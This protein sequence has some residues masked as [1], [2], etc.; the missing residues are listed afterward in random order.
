MKKVVPRVLICI[1]SFV[2][3][4][5]VGGNSFADNAAEVVIQ[6]SYPSGR[7][8]VSFYNGAV[9][10]IDT[11][12]K[13]YSINVHITLLDEDGN[14]ATAGPA[15]ESLSGLTATLTT[16]LGV[17]SSIIENQFLSDSADLTFDVTDVGPAARAHVRYACQTGCEPGDD[18][19]EVTVDSLTD[20]IE[21][22]VRAPVSTSLVARTLRV[23]GAG[24]VDLFDTISGQSHNAGLGALAGDDIYFEIWAVEENGDFTFAPELQGQVVTVNAYADYDASGTVGD[25]FLSVISGPISE[26]PA[27]ATATA[28]MS[29]GKATGYI[30]I[31]EAGNKDNDGSIQLKVVLTA[32]MNSVG[33]SQIGTDPA[34]TDPTLDWVG[35][36]P[37][38]KDKFLIGWDASLGIGNLIDETDIWYVIDDNSTGPTTTLMH[39]FIVDEYGNPVTGESASIRSTVSG[40]LADQGYTLVDANGENGGTGDAWDITAGVPGNGNPGLATIQSDLGNNQQEETDGGP[41]QSIFTLEDEDLLLDS[42]SAT[43]WLVRADTS[44]PNGL[45][46]HLDTDRPGDVITAG[47]TVTLYITSASGSSGNPTNSEIVEYNDDLS[48]MVGECC[49]PPLMISKS[50][51]DYDQ[52]T[53]DPLGLQLKAPSPDPTTKHIEIPIRIYGPCD[54]GVGGVCISLFDSDKGVSSRLYHLSREIGDLQP[55]AASRVWIDSLPAGVA[56]QNNDLTPD[57]IVITSEFL[58]GEN[59][60]LSPASVDTADQYNNIVDDT[61]T[62][63]IS[64]DTGTASV[65]GTRA[66]SITFDEDD[67]GETATVTV[68]VSGVGERQ[69]LITDILDST[70]GGALVCE[71]EGP[72]LPTPGGETIIQV[73][74]NREFTPTPK[75]V[76]VSIDTAS[77]V[78]DS[79]LRDFNG[80]ALI[81]P[82][83]QTLDSGSTVRLVVSAPEEGDVTVEVSDLSA[84]PFDSGT[85]TVMFY[86]D[87]HAP[88]ASIY[89]PDGSLVNPSECIV[90]TVIDDIAVDLGGTEY[91]IEKDGTDITNTLECEKEGH[92]TREG[93]ITC[94][95][96]GGLDPGSYLVSVTPKDLVGYVGTEITSAFTVLTCTLTVII[97]P[98]SA[99]LNPGETIQF[100]AKTT[101]NG[102]TLT[103]CY[104]WEI[105]EGCGTFDDNGL[106]TAGNSACTATITVTD[107]CNGN[108]TASAT[109]AVSG[110]HRILPDPMRRSRWVMLPTLM[111][112]Q[113]DSANFNILTSR[114]SFS[115]ARAVTPLPRLVLG[116]HTIWQ[117]VFVNPPWLAG[118]AT[119]GTLTVTVTTGTET[120]TGDTNIQMLPFGLDVQ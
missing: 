64:S 23:P 36:K 93:T 53:S 78:M 111:V 72:G 1:L 90:I 79:E 80:T 115:P 2:F 119:D 85:C 59:T 103:G 24:P 33:T 52:A 71:V 96:D 14:P 7:G 28:E 20:S 49:G 69:L 5:G 10:D 31:E 66:A 70:G 47:D 75:T 50:T 18:T 48:I 67:I 26:D 45:D 55:A 117:L 76:Q 44:A 99:T 25:F 51:E 22:D 105:S 9:G 108:I 34:T 3:V 60:L 61:P 95:K 101:C 120:V 89:P 30:T 21:V 106:F 74:A 109:V 13:D 12:K 37:G 97:T 82:T 19:L 43:V 8:Y 35:M 73:K 116:P 110:G 92:G 11:T 91:S 98:A 57:T 86:Y 54:T 100:S 27:I 46:L 38:I 81:L 83:S 114:V 87:P 118:G 107:T 39:V 58:V 56:A 17:A 102:D 6:L 4:C 40:P 15:G 65:D 88:T 42:D 113:N 77:S 84:D 41:L 104:V 68:N 62:Y 32:S 29:S 63:G 16:Q 94:C 112:L